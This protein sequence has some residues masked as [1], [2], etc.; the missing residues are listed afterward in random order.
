MSRAPLR[1]AIDA[2]SAVRGG[3]TTYLRNLIPHLSVEGLQLAILL[4]R[5]SVS[6]GEVGR[7]FESTMESGS[8]VASL[9][10][11]WHRALRAAE[12]DI[13]YCPTEIAAPALGIPV[14]TALRSP[15]Y[16]RELQWEH[17]PL[18][19]ARFGIK[20]HLARAASKRARR[21]IAISEF[22]ASIG[23]RDLGIPRAKIDVVYHGAPE[24]LSDKAERQHGPV[25]NLLF[26][27]NLSVPYKNLHRLLLALR[28]V[29]GAWNLTVAGRLAGNPYTDHLRSIIQ[30]PE[31]Q[32]RVDLRGHCSTSE[33]RALYRRS[34]CLVWP[35]Y[36]ETFGHPLVE[37]ATH[38]L[39]ILAADTE[40]AR[41]IAGEAA[42]YFDPF[43]IRNLAQALQKAVTRGVTVGSLPRA[44]TWKRCAQ[45]T[46]AVLRRA[47]TLGMNRS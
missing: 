20:R 34:D 22:A 13:V 35:S 9:G 8:R 25:E 7:F 45:R 44:Y 31:L 16:R 6:L 42:I 29:K 21:V 23:V 27:S 1:V 41:E 18:L 14:V 19:R 3:G 12:V 33:L 39:P 2:S 37:A 4:R 15:L 17:P 32:D 5:S 40:V 46:A 11:A 30:H 38:G 10:P 26:V 36:A 47:S 43:E 28:G 24:H